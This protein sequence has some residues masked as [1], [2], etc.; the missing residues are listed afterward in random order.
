MRGLVYLFSPQPFRTWL[1]TRS[2]SGVTFAPPLS[3][4]NLTVVLDMNL[5]DKKLRQLASETSS[6]E[7]WTRAHAVMA[8]TPTSAFPPLLYTFNP[9]RRDGEPHLLDALNSKVAALHHTTCRWGGCHPSRGEPAV[10]WL[11]W[12][13]SAPWPST[14]GLGLD[15]TSVV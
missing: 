4:A 1:Q 3:P 5:G 13:S 15:S 12:R 9:S 14:F 11:K 10:E 7:P 8:A 2:L 6:E